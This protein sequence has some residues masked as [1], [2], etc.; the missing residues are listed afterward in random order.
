MSEI[1]LSDKLHCARRELGYRRLVY[2]KAVACKRMTQQKMDREIALM[3]AIVTDYEAQVAALPVAPPAPDLFNRRSEDTGNGKQ[4]EATSI[5]TI[6]ALQL[7]VRDWVALALYGQTDVKTR[8]ARF[9]EEAAEAAQAA[10]LH[11][12]DAALVLEQVYQREPG[13]LPQE[14]G[15]SMT[16]LCALAVVAGLDLEEASLREM[17]R[18][19]TPEIIDKV[20]RRQAGKVTPR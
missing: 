20:R 16:T 7:R 4:L 19:E 3:E 14:L 17:A 9:L 13:H 12:E 18:V 15:G 11:R 2:E 1:T 5:C 10:G 8:A 6:S